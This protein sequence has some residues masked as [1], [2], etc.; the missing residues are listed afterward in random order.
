MESSENTP[1]HTLN[2]NMISN[3]AL[4]DVSTGTDD[5]EYVPPAE[6]DNI[7]LLMPPHAAE[8]EKIPWTDFHKLHEPTQCGPGRLNLKIYVCLECLFII[9]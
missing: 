9:E 3:V 5:Q 7:L 1:S 6:A 4:A 2:L 8:K